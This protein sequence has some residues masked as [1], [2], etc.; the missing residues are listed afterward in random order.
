MQQPFQGVVGT[1]RVADAS[2]STRGPRR[3]AGVGL[4]PAVNRFASRDLLGDL[5]RDFIICHL[6]DHSNRLDKWARQPAFRSDDIEDV[7]IRR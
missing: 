6:I 5:L 2:P 3:G 1:T 4:G 7:S